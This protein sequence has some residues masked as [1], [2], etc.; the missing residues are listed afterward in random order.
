MKIK[1][2]KL[3]GL[4]TAAIALPTLYAAPAMADNNAV[5]S[6]QDSSNHNVRSKANELKN[7]KT[8]RRTSDTLD[9][10]LA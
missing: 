4:V 5:Y 6:R 2:M 1:S 3:A 8:M 10:L 7:R 9:R